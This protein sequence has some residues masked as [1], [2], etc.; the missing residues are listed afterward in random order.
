[1]MKFSRNIRIAFFVLGLAIVLCSLAALLFAYGP[2]QAL[3]DQV[4]LAP[5][6]FSPP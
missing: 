3:V 6:L 2:V 4:P 1:M 5:T